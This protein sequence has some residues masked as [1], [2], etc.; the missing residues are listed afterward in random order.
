MILE[1]IS[2]MR[3]RKKILKGPVEL[4]KRKCTDIAWLIGFVIAAVISLS[5]VMT[6]TSFLEQLWMLE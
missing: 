2:L 1:I 6:S 3:A 5:L 4:V